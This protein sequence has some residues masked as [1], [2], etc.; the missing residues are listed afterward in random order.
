MRKK[1]E[2]PDGWDE[3][4]VQRVLT[5]YEKQTDD[6]AVAGD[7]RAW[8]DKEASAVQVPNAILAEVL[9]LIE[10]YRRTHSSA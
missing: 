3:A 5:H 10:G 4:R 6:E 8:A 2:F 1:T 9:A 7:K